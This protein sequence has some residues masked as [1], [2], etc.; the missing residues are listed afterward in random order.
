MEYEFALVKPLHT[1]G[2]L[3]Y[4]GFYFCN[5]KQKSSSLY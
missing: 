1:L 2:A 4:S 3:G 5:N